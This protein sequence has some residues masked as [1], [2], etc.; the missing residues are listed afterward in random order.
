MAHPAPADQGDLGVSPEAVEAAAEAAAQEVEKILSNE[1][2]EP[3]LAKK[4]RSRLATGL[5]LG[6]A[7]ALMAVLAGGLYASQK[8]LVEE[9][10]PEKPLIFPPFVSPKAS[11]GP[12]EERTPRDEGLGSRPPS[13]DIEDQREYGDLDRQRR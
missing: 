10:A 4:P 1:G 3:A 8:L 2:V 9:G 12:T 7:L 11:P 6:A 13:S 5:G